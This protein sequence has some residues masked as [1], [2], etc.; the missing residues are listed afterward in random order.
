MFELHK[1]KP[2]PSGKLGFQERGPWR[3]ENNKLQSSLNT[4]FNGFGL[5]SVRLSCISVFTALHQQWQ[6]IA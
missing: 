1:R 5:Y 4:L 6:Y 2:V 3:F